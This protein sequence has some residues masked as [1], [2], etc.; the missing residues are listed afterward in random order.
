MAIETRRRVR[1]RPNGTAPHPVPAG[2]ALTTQRYDEQIEFR[3]QPMIPNPC[4]SRRRFRVLFAAVTTAPTSSARQSFAHSML[5]LRRWSLETC[6]RT[7]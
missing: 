1:H 6:C 4:L 2:R 7:S 3:W 5:L